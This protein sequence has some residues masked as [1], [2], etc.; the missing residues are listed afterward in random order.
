MTNIKFIYLN[1]FLLSVSVLCFEIVST[2]ISSVIFVNDYAFIILSL[3]ILGLG[4][5]SIYSYYKIKKEGHDFFYFISRLL[6]FL[7]ASYCVFIFTVIIAAVTNSIFYL[8]L[9]FIPFFIA[10][11]IYAQLFKTFAADSFKIYAADLIGGACGSIASLGIINTLGAPNG[12]IFLAIIIFT[13]AISFA[14]ELFSTQRQILGYSFLLIITGALFFNGEKELIGSVPIG[15]F[16]EKDYYHVYADPTVRSKIIESR[17]SNY[18]RSDLVQYN[19]QDVVKQLFIDG[20]AGTQMYRFNGNVSHTDHLLLDLLLH[21]TSAIPFLCLNNSE[22]NTM[23]IIGPGGG[24]EVLIGLFGEVKKITAVEVNPDFVQIVK[25]YKDYNGGIYTDF[26]NVNVLVQEGRHFVKKTQTKFNLVVMALPSTE[27]TQSVEPFAMSENYLLTEEAI[28]DY[29]KILTQDGS[30]IFTVHNQWELV[31]LIATTISAFKEIGIEGYEVQNHYAIIESEYAP[32]IV[33]KKNAFT[34][35]QVLHWQNVLKSLPNDLPEVTY[36]PFSLDKIKQTTVNRFLI[37]A[38]EHTELLQ[39]FIERS[40][41]DISPCKDDKPYFYNTNKGAPKEYLQLLGCITLFNVMVIWFPI[42]FIKRKSKMEQYRD[43]ITPLI[44]FICIG[45]GF[46]IIEVSLFQ[47][48]ILYLGSPTTSLS[49]LLSSLL[50]GMGLGSYFGKML[51][52]GN[53]VK[54]IYMVSLFIVVTGIL[55]FVLYPMILSEL[56]L[57]SL[58]IRSFACFV[59]ILPFAFLMGIPFPS[60]IQLLEQKKMEK[61]IPWMYGVNG[62]MSVLGSIIAVNISMTVGFTPTFFVGVAVYFIL[63]VILFTQEKQLVY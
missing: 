44:I 20:S 55:I 29:L 10:G 47:K 11:I 34:R 5:G 48:F 32:T 14:K 9:L 51:F 39:S 31:R 7:G 4:C 12:V 52:G 19:H 2:R 3:S 28:K 23:L 62:S 54:R 22:K 59:I 30:L 58:I 6:I 43:I 8:F 15:D 38:T 57:F 25:E 21:Q 45:I 46:M 1:V 56:L 17:W 53:V 49:V 61:Y 41:D 63:G 26:P 16:P 27:Q 24:K 37:S 40:N 18:G 60:C 33:I 35:E 36:L 42:K 13:V 50:V